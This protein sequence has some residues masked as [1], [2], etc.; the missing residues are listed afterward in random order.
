MAIH[1]YLLLIVIKIIPQIIFI[2]FLHDGFQVLLDIVTDVAHLVNIL[3]QVVMFDVRDLRML[4]ALL[5]QVVKVVI[6]HLLY[7]CHQFSVE[8]FGVI[9]LL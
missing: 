4:S 2:K 1:L 8:I 9:N 7:E 3:P 6:S 5:V